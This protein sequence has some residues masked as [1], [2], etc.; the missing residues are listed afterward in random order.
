[1]RVLVT[2]GAGFIGSHYVRQVLTRAYPTLVDQAGKTAIA[3]GVG[4]VPETY[5]LNAAGKIVAKFDG[6]MTSNDLDV[7]IRKAMQ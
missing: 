3:Y 5:F 4:G 7:N 2:G 6:P 1:M